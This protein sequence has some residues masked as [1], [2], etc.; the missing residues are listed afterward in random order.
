MLSRLDLIQNLARVIGS[1]FLILL[2]ANAAYVGLAYLRGMGAEGV[3]TP[4]RARVIG[5]SLT[6]TL[7]YSVVMI[8]AIKLKRK[9][10][11]EGVPSFDRPENL[12]IALAAYAVSLLFTVPFSLYLRGEFTI[13]PFLFA[14]SQAVLGYF[15][16]IYVDRVGRSA[17]ISFTAAAWQGALQLAA[18]LI[19]FLGAPPLPG[20]MLSF[21]DVLSFSAFV[22]IQSALSGFLIG[23]LFQ[24]LRAMPLSV[25]S[26]NDVAARG[27]AVLE[28]AL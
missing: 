19:A 17:G 22:A 1:M 25:K 18:T 24:H 14:S 16:G 2:V 23:V 9:W 13:A 10:R 27:I 5:Y 26:D 4:N 11:H 6:F 20:P 8:L 12:L 7:N 15:I 28:S 21:L 3:L